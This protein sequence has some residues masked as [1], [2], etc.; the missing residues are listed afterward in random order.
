MAEENDQVTLT[1]DGQDITAR[2]GANLLEVAREN[3]FDIPGICYHPRLS[4]TASC[5]LCV[6]KIDGSEWP[7]PACTTQVEEGME[8]VAFDD[9]LEKH[10]RN[11]I[12]LMLSK[13]NC[14]C[15]T[16]DSAGDCDVQK[17][18]Y[19]YGLI[20]LS[21]EKFR[22]VYSNVT[23]KYQS[24]PTGRDEPKEMSPYEAGSETYTGEPKDCIRCG[25]CVE[26]C[27]MNLSPVLIMEASEIYTQ[28]G[29]LEDLHPEDCI[30]CGLCSFVCPGQIRI[31]DYFPEKEK[32]E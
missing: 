8:V 4:S 14:T 24:F 2:K 16:C 10:R 6:V 3:G 9:E 13:H 12:D 15:I 27:P 26:V 30:E 7:E 25:Y 23:S 21:P 29:S 22:D 19:R 18:G 1:I 11:L 17:L 28:P 31:P 5:R 20:G 32:V